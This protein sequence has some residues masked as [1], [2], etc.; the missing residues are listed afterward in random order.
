MV[1]WKNFPFW[2]IPKK[3]FWKSGID[4][5]LYWRQIKFSKIFEV[6]QVTNSHRLKQNK[7]KKEKRGKRVHWPGIEPGPPAWQARILPLNHQCS[8]W[9]MVLINWTLTM[10]TFTQIDKTNQDSV[11]SNLF[12]VLGWQLIVRSSTSINKIQVSLHNDNL[13]NHPRWFPF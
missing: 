5:F 8:A 9:P 3:R 12:Y 4:P 11:W 2:R 7:K 1:H 10:W 6:Q 13:Y